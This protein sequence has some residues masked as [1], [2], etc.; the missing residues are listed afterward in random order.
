MRE[1]FAV[2]A[3]ALV[4][5]FSPAQ[6]LESTQDQPAEVATPNVSPGPLTTVH[7]VVRYGASGEP[8]PRAL[9]RISGDAAAGALT[10]GDGRFEIANVPVGPQQ[11]EVIKPGFMDRAASA[12]SSLEHQHSFGHNVIV[13]AGM[14]DIVFSM[15][16]VNAIRGVIQLSTGEPAR[17]IQ[18]T[19]LK[20]TVQDGRVA[21][22]A[23][24]AIRTNSEGVYRFGGLADG[25]Y[26]LYTEPTM[27]S[28]AA[29]NLVESGRGRSVE[30]GGYASVFYP[31]ATDLAG[32]A[33]IRLTGG[34]TAQADLRLALEP[35]H[36]VAATIAV[37]ASAGS[38]V[39]LMVLDTG[40][41][42]LPY[43]AQYDAN[44]RTMQALLPDGTYSLVAIASKDRPP[45]SPGN[46]SALT[47]LGGRV[48]TGQADVS[49][50]GRAVSNLRIPLAAARMSPVQVSV[51]RT[52]V[53]P[54]SYSNGGANASGRDS[55]V[56]VTLSQTGAWTSDGIVTSFAQGDSAGTLEP[57]FVP[58]GSYWA[59]T[60]VAQ[61]GLCE[62]SF[63]AGGTN[64]ARE[65]LVIGFSGTTAPLNLTLRDDCASLTIALPASMSVPAAGEEPFYTVYVV[66]DFESTMDVMPQT[67][68]ASSGS[69][70]TLAGLTPGNYH[71][72][73]FN[74]PVALEYR[75]PVV[76]AG[77]RGQAVTLGP[78]EER[79]LVVE[80]GQ[81]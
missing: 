42:P 51:M 71:V 1:M 7:G 67:L 32:S 24:G 80:A 46:A 50:S 65:P 8:L 25:E 34:D 21:W 41:H 14:Q 56:V 11:F 40:G 38:N 5:V 35:F 13:V 57:T 61:K 19:L 18:V 75:N 23:A 10:D 49:V 78:G 3:L 30:R 60:S 76:L 26:A 81:Q 59:H 12:E 37:P 33:K 36:L 54:A 47:A 29:T 58:P 48:F 64:L 62:A 69:R 15:T 6:A 17:A 70:V 16:R 44:T 9:V 22:Q 45:G 52:G 77:L 39:S 27:E 55:E 74:N 73:V 79:E 43:N 28:E 2:A 53:T 4:G 63:T 31:D 66:P 72:Y 68:R 20:R